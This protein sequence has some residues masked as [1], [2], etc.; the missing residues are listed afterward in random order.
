[1]SPGRRV[2]FVL[3]TVAVLALSSVGAANASSGAEEAVVPSCLQEAVDQTLHD[4]V[5]VLIA[6]VKAV[7]EDP[8]GLLAAEVECVASVLAH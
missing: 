5:G 1:M 7:V 6:D 3:T 4:P 8:G 2:G